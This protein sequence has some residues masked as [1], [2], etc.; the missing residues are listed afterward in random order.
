MRILVCGD[1]NWK[2]R[3]F[4]ERIIEEYASNAL[5]I[6][7]GCAPGVDTFA[8]KHAKDMSYECLAFPADWERYGKA[9]GPVRNKRMLVE[10]KPDIV[11]AI[12]SDIEISKGTKNMIFQANKAGVPVHLYAT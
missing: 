5:I 9:A 2:D 7:S 4:V 3:G 11:V 8:V 1:R 12:H 10:G 6:I